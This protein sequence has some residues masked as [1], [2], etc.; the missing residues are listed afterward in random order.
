MRRRTR[1]A[2][3]CS[4]LVPLSLVV[5]DARAALTPS[6]LAQLRDSVASAKGGTV[7]ARVR[8]LV[9]RPD[10][11]DDESSEAL[12]QA[13]APVPFTPARATLLKDVVFGGASVASRPILAMATVK[14][15]VARA[16]SLL[17][18]YAGGLDTQPEA[19]AELTRI[20]AFV[21][22]E[23]AAAPGRRG[24]GQEPQNGISLAAYDECSRFLAEHMDR[25]PKWLRDE[26][27][28][29]PPAS[30]V[31][32]QMKLAL[33][34]M[35]NE[36]PTMRVEAADRLGLA[37]A[38]R[39]FFTELGILL[40]DSGVA[41]DARIDRVRALVARMPAVRQSTSAIFFG[42]PKPDL[43]ARG[44]VLGV[45]SSLESGRSSAGPVSS[46]ARENPFPAEVEPGAVDPA[47]LDLARELGRVVVTRALDKRGELRLRAERDVRAVM[48][49]ASKLLGRAEL[50]AESALA[51]AVA[52]L[53][54]D[55]PR[56]L[57]LAMA[58]F[59]AGRPESA[60]I[61]SD[62]LGV[63]AAHS[64]AAPAS[65]NAGLV[66]ALGAPRDDGSTENLSATQVQLAADGSVSAFTIRGAKWTLVRGESGV[67]TDVRK[68]GGPLTLGALATARI[69]VREATEWKGGGMAFTR[70]AGTPRAAVASG[71]RVRVVGASRGVDAIAMPSPSNDVVVDVD[72]D[73]YGGT[74]GVLV[75]AA[76]G[77]SGLRGAG[78]VIDPNPKNGTM[79]VSLRAFDAG[80]GAEIVPSQEQRYVRTV[81]VRLSVK[82]NK[83]EATAGGITLRG[84][85]P[86]GLATGSVALHAE[87]GASVEAAGLVAHKR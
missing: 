78:V 3:V 62:A 74:G 10:L 16:D 12:A 41:D 26:A 30:R 23:I 2:L 35:M 80:T 84:V 55:G 68:N 1:W 63:L 48:G 31:R 83:I 27:R 53:L 71:S 7:P 14:A 6:E 45:A 52:L 44:L 72:L 64:G 69:P 87:H 65:P 24:L 42:A 33:L 37:G 66:L 5:S 47:A 85:L 54:L 32:A 57:D 86:P 82:G 40:L 46:L 50:S 21:D 76:E 60:A 20:Y 77:D 19:M 18:K 49:D 8:A 79:R 73:V 67:V 22:K 81:H 34:D 43:V 58:R 61:A 59:L 13:V 9:A 29:A 39:S 25:N 70:L 38:R 15:L 75:R 4:A 28:L 51:E 17:A 56:T 11:S 36:S